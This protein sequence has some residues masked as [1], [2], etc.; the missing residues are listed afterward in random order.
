MTETQPEV[1]VIDQLSLDDYRLICYGLIGELKPE[2]K[3]PA[4]DLLKRIMKR[5]F[6]QQ[7]DRW[8]NSQSIEDAVDNF[9]GNVESNHG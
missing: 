6:K 5:L 7:E 1:I 8:D 3:I 4:R 9:V 2:D